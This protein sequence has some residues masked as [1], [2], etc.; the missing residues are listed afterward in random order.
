MPAPCYRSA[1]LLHATIYTTN[2]H[3]LHWPQRAKSLHIRSSGLVTSHRCTVKH[4]FTAQVLCND[5]TSIALNPH[6]DGI[7]DGTN[8]SIHCCQLAT[9]PCDT[10]R[11]KGQEQGP[12]RLACTPGGVMRKYFIIQEFQS[13]G[14]LLLCHWQHH[15]WCPFLTFSTHKLPQYRTMLLQLHNHTKR[16][17]M[18]LKPPFVTPPQPHHAPCTQAVHSS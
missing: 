2:C 7:T 11:T 3:M 1:P 17:F 16:R 12:C 18:H 10:R 14:L 6:G 9:A 4:T 5:A 13:K 15:Q 8:N